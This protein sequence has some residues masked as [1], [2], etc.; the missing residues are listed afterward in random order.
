MVYCFADGVKFTKKLE[1]ITI[2]EKDDIVFT[3]TI[4]DPKIKVNWYKDEL[5]LV[6]DH[7]ILID[8]DERNHSLS[9]PWTNLDDTGSYKAM[10]GFSKSIA[11][12]AV[13]GWG[14]FD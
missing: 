14:F 13:K 9:I 2:D 8:T 11:T 5:L 7:R 4:S 6:S 1:D 10:A 3:C 12:L